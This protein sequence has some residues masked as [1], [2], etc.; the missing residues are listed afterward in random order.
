MFEVKNHVLKKKRDEL[1]VI[2]LHFSC[3][4]CSLVQVQISVVLSFVRPRRVV[5]STPYSQDLV[6]PRG[7]SIVKVSRSSDNFYYVFGWFFVL[8]SEI[9]YR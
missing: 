1:V 9:L 5:G 4:E 2:S 3:L 7:T 6:Y 8:G